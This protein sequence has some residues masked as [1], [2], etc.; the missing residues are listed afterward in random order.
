MFYLGMRS[1]KSEGMGLGFASL[2]IVFLLQVAG[3]PAAHADNSFALKFHAYQS[4]IRDGKSAFDKKDFKAAVGQYS[5]A[6]ELSLFEAQS[7]FKRGVSLFKTGKEKEAVGDFNKSL[8]INPRMSS[9]YAYRGMCREKLGEYV[10][11]LKD[12]TSALAINPSDAG[13]HN[14]L[15]WLYATAGDEKVKDKT[16]ALEHAKKAA[17]LSHGKNAEILDTLARAYFINGQIKEAVEAEKK[18]LKLSPDNE[19]FKKSVRI[20]E[21][22]IPTLP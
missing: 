9:A 17:E 10:A 8:I 15:A 6:I 5:K 21:Q 1:R 13:L 16:E 4:A 12:Y 7:Y 22:A 2:T 3:P 18:A 19:R 20:Y 14:N 11:A